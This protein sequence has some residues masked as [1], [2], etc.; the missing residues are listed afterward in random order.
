MNTLVSEVNGN[1]VPVVYGGKGNGESVMPY[2]HQDQLG[3]LQN[4]L[5]TLTE[6]IM[7]LNKKVSDVEESM[8]E[9]VGN[10]S[11]TNKLIVDNAVTTFVGKKQVVVETRIKEL[12]QETVSA[13]RGKVLSYVR[14]AGGLGGKNHGKVWQLA[15]VKLQELTG[16][17]VYKHG[18]MAAK[19]NGEH[20]GDSYLNTVINK[21]Y[22]AHLVLVLE[23]L[24]N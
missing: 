5:N 1:C 15:Y 14:L 2:K 18:K 17:D 12:E 8:L 20:Y 9:V 16:F 21:G 10:A 13:L 7:V 23:G 11:K 19:F 4:Q 22:L 24:T 6:V 3:I